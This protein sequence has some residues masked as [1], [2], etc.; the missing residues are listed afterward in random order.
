MTCWFR[1]RLTLWKL[2]LLKPS[3]RIQLEGFN[4][5]Q[6]K[7]TTRHPTGLRTERDR[8]GGALARSRGRVAS[9]ARASAGKFYPKRKGLLQK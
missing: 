4:W 5:K 7:H 9:K 3:A 6:L 8:R 2:N 1:I